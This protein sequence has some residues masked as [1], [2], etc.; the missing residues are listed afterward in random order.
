MVC[1]LAPGDALYLPGGV[2]HYVES[3]ELTVS[4][5]FTWWRF[6][7]LPRLMLADLYKRA[8]RHTK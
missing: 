5:G 2:S 6:A 7:D 8:R 1:E 3:D 4:V